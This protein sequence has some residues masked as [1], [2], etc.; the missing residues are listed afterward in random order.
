MTQNVVVK[1]VD[2][3]NCVV[4][5]LSSNHI[6]YFSDIYAKHAPGYFFNP[7]YKLG[8]WDGKIRYFRKDG[9]T[10]TYLL[11]GLV[12]KI[13]ALGYGIAISDL[14]E[15]QFISVDPI[16]EK[17]FSHILDNENNPFIFRE[18][19][20]GA[21]N[22]VT[23]DGGGVVI[24]GTGAGKTAIAAAIADLYGR[25]GCKTLTIVPNIDLIEQTADTFNYLGLDVGEYSGTEKDLTHTH[26]ISTWQALQNNPQI[27]RLFQV[28]IVDEVHGAKGNVIQK[29]LT[30]NGSHI[31]HR[32]G[33]TGTLPKEETDIMAI[34]V[35]IGDVKYNITAH[36]LIKQNWLASLHISIVQLVENFESGHF[37]DYDA[38]R[39]YLQTKKERLDWIAASIIEKSN[40]RKGNVMCLVSNI[41]FGKR[42]QKRI[43]GSFFLHGK[44]KRVVRKEAYDLFENN[45]NV[46]VIATAQIAGVG[47]SIDRIF[48]LFLIDIGKSFIRVIQ[49]IGRGL[50]KG[51]DK[52]HVDVTDVCSDLK[53]AKKHLR[54]RIKY[55][56]EALYPH[57]KSVVHYKQKE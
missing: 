51:K 33:L 5:G 10:F 38:E 21:I 17:Y 12:Q 24:A 34:R 39:A 47:L 19:Q 16:D 57:K 55:Y 52:D 1:I 50:R 48:N 44:D 14:R 8:Q 6:D 11:D 20:V 26:T 42:L 30:E 28:V 13:T 56:N 46:V 37:P 49:T 45:N 29:L 41:S 18:Y 54:E 43:P 15:G 53:Y 35:A 9:K 31:V 25:Q 7:K 4:M 23:Q 32:F 27:M 2:E 36:E 22:S 3:V 40:L